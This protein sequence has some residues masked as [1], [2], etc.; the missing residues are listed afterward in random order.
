MISLMLE[1]FEN[2][3]ENGSGFLIILDFD[4]HNKRF[5]KRKAF[6]ENETAPSTETFVEKDSVDNSK[7]AQHILKMFA[8]Y[9]LDYKTFVVLTPI[10][11]VICKR[12]ATESCAKFCQTA[13]SSRAS[14]TP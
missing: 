7:A 12:I 2:R 11:P 3:L 8:N 14:V 9:R 5:F 4:N 1:S 10:S 13:I 6:P